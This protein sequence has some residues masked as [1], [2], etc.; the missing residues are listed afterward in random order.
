M[1]RIRHF[2]HHR[3]VGLRATMF[4]FDTD[5]PEQAKLADDLIGRGGA[6]DRLAVATFAPDTLVE[7]RNRGFRPVP[8]RA[9]AG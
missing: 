1:P 3:F 4:V 9:I 5:D 7:A 6:L 8:L 2:E